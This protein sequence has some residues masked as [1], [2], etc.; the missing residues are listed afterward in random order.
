MRLIKFHLSKTEENDWE[1]DSTQFS[2][3]N[4]LVGDSGTGKTRFLNAIINLFSQLIADKIRF[5]GNWDVDFEADNIRYNY[6]LNVIRNKKSPSEIAIEYEV[7][8]KGKQAIFERKGDNILWQNSN[9]PKLSSDMTCFSLLKNEDI[10]NPIYK[11]MKKIIARRFYADELNKNFQLGAFIPNNPFIPPIVKIDDLA[12]EQID[13]H[14]KMDMLRKI[15]LSGY[16]KIIE[17]IKSAFPFIVEADIKNISQILPLYPAPVQTPVFCIKEKN[18]SAWI[19]CNDISSGM[20][21]IFLLILDT[22]LLQKSGILLIDE[23]E[24]S[25]GISAINFL[26]DLINNI[27][28]NCQF[29]ITSHHPYIINNIP[30]ES[31]KLFHRS[32]TN[33][34][35]TDG[36]IL[37][38]KYS[39]SRQEQFIQLINDPVYNGGIE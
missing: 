19:P 33:V 1:F 22:Y 18:L 20:Q 6:K 4:L 14:N 13:F 25:L 8:S 24:N 2:R 5:T 29:I 21:K 15:D 26:P 35:I 38:E 30:I 11:S 12:V 37:K 9:L 10:I 27:S 23:Y 7:L 39:K 17:F 31:W 16:N 34:H 3:I 28:Q 36:V 32:G